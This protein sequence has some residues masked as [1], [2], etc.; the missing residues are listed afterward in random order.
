MQSAD[1]LAFDLHKQLHVT[2]DCGA[3]L[4][5]DHDVHR[6][7]FELLPAY[8]EKSK[9]RGLAAGDFW[10]SQYS[11]Q[12]SSGFRALKVWS[13]IKEHGVA[14]LRSMVTKCLEVAAHW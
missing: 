12:L 10:P 2:Y 14:R 1:S 3:V 11:V 13:T 6:A 8:L 5:K 4:V 9:T 7:T